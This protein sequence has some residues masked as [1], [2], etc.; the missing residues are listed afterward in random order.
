MTEST[1][2][3]VL[4]NSNDSNSS[5]PSEEPSTTSVLSNATIHSENLYSENAINVEPTEATITTAKPETII[6]MLPNLD[7]LPSFDLGTPSDE[8]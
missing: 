4:I 1:D 8:P 6:P 2:P 3:E 5:K 7:P